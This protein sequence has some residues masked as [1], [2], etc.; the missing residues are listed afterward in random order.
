MERGP[1]TTLEGLRSLAKQNKRAFRK[2]GLALRKQKNTLQQ[3]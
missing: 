2:S 3:M 1:S